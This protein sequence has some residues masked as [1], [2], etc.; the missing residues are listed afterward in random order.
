MVSGIGERLLLQTGKDSTLSAITMHDFLRSLGVDPDKLAWQ[1]LAACQGATTNL[2]F[3]DYETD[4]RTA[5]MIDQMCL[6]CPVTKECFE[7]GVDNKEIGVFGGFYL[8]NGQPDKRRNEHK[9]REVAVRLAGKVY[10]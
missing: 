9:D 3:D 6:S 8:N 7:F 1:D 10:E 2:F 4:E 5:R